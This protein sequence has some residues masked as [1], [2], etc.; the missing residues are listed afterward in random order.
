MPNEA[1]HQAPLY[2]THVHRS[3]LPPALRSRFRDLDQ[4]MRELAA[5]ATARLLVTAPYLSVLGME[6]LRDAIAVAAGNGASV[7]VVTGDVNRGGPNCDALQ[8][9]SS[10]PGGLVLRRRCRILASS[11]LF[12]VLLHAKLIVADR[13]RGYLGSANLSGRALEDNFEVGV[14]LQPAQARSLDDLITYL[15][16][17]GKLIDRTAEVWS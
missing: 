2:I 14:A 17:Q 9:L 3:D 11:E 13:E 5:S 6:Y 15:E 8:A 7:R 16:S 12:P 10:G 4:F 1:S